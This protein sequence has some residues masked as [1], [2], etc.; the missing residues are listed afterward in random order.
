MNG[1]S[2]PFE[3]YGVPVKIWRYLSF[4]VSAFIITNDAEADYIPNAIAGPFIYSSTD[5]TEIE[6][7]LV[8]DF[9]YQDGEPVLD[10]TGEPVVGQQVGD[11]FI[12]KPPAFSTK[13]PRAQVNYCNP[14]SSRAVSSYFDTGGFFKNGALPNR[15]YCKQFSMYYLYTD[16]TPI[17]IAHATPLDS[18][19]SRWPKPAPA[20]FGK[21]FDQLQNK[22][23][24]LRYLSMVAIIHANGFDSRDGVYLWDTKRLIK[25]AP[26]TTIG[27]YEGFLSFVSG[28]SDTPEYFDDGADEIRYV[29]CA[30]SIEKSHPGFYCTVYFPISRGAFVELS[31]V[32]F[33]LHGGRQFLRERVRSFKRLFCEQLKCDQQSINAA[34]VGE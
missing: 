29:S 2:K 18:L 32:D 12:T 8:Y 30:S 16:G 33:R 7:N 24:M 15:I 23:D 11:K 6:V 3:K 10:E 21:D 1:D 9:K 27:D 22:W 34:K 4:L 13:L 19:K 28:A 17:T 5:L 31:F 14:Y 26:N 25:D 20:S